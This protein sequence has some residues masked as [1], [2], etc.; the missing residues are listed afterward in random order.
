[1]RAVLILFQLDGGDYNLN[2]MSQFSNES[3]YQLASS[4][5]IPNLQHLYKL[6]L[7]YKTDGYFVE[8]GAYDGEYVSNTSGLADLGWQ[9]IYIEPVE[10]YFKACLNRHSNNSV[11]VIHCAAGN[12]EAE[13]EI[14]V[15]G[16]LSSMSAETVARFQDFDWAKGFHNGQ[17]EKV[18]QSTLDDILI[19]NN[20]PIGFD[21]LSVDV[22][23]Y[24]LNVFQGFSINKWKPKM[25]IVELHDNNYV[26]PHQWSE[27]DQIDQFLRD[28]EYRII[29]KDYSNTIFI[30][31]GLKRH[32]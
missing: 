30:S 31:K 28:A 20:A 6:F 25:I 5:Q 16:P 18:M 3:F 8:V 17:K 32:Q 21:I 7:G 24:E 27:C 15:G 12:K 2:S 19:R 13:I 10:Q 26:Y 11:R 9:G 14:Y 4:C 22:E 23:G 29:Y 1:M